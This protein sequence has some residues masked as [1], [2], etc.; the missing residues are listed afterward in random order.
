MNSKWGCTSHELCAQNKS[1]RMV[2]AE[3]HNTHYTCSRCG[4]REVQS[5]FTC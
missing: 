4:T 5:A 3:M 2:Y 1:G